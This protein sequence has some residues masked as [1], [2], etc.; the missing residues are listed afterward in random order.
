MRRR[1]DA[2]VVALEAVHGDE[3]HMIAR[4]AQADALVLVERGEG[5]LSAGSSVRYLAG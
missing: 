3:S 1:A 4:A 5:E 2:D